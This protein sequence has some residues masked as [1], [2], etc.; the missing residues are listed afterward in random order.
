ME[1][2][3]RREVVET[4]ETI[5][6]KVGTNTL[7]RPDDTL[8]NDRIV[9]L[10][11]QLC[12]IRES[13]RKVVLVSSG[14]VAAGMELLSLRERPRDLPHLQAAAAAGQAHLIHLYDKALRDRGYHAAQMLVTGIDF[15]HRSRYL[16]VRNT[17]NTL[18][19]YD[20]IPIVNENDTV[21]VDEVK[22][23]DNDHLA[24]MVCN[25]LPNPL[26]IILTSVDGLYDGDPA[27]SGSHVIPL[28]KSWDDGLEQLSVE[29]RTSRGTGGMQSKLQAVKMATKVGESVILANGHHPGILSRI[30]EA[31]EVG[32]LF[33]ADG[34]ALP[35]WKRW[36]GFT[37]PPKGFLT[38]DDGAV[39]ALRERGK[40]LLAIGIK[41]SEGTFSAGELVAIK[42]E[43][44]REIG[45][46]LSNYNSEQTLKI[47]GCRPDEMMIILGDLPYQEVIHRDNLVVFQ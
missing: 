19:E 40:S 12:A 11:E 33:L 21:S 36:I 26:L 16:N 5:V 14:A 37:V 45:R 47:C 44:G 2:L 18:F 3:V 30:L 39:A 25:L 13:G 23:G 27:D 24:A 43:Q 9:H 1:N 34:R 15:K 29:T 10:A 22:F 46:G 31:E 7:A 41:S 42:N 6:V 35:A 38:V 4:A 32:T 8:D 20:V 28:I 17:L